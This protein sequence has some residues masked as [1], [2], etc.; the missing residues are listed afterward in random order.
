M[1]VFLVMSCF[2][3][4]GYV[5]VDV[6]V[7]F[8]LLLSFALQGHRTTN[9]FYAITTDY[10]ICNYNIFYLTHNYNKLL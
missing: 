3:I 1:V 8:F 2:S 6:V 10:L 7:F 9:Y 5:F 4:C